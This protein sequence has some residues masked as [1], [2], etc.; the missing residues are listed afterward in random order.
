MIVTTAALLLIILWKCKRTTKGTASSTS[1]YSTTVTCDNHDS[2][3]EPVVYYTSVEPPGE[4]VYTKRYVYKHKYYLL[5]TDC[6]VSS[7]P[8]TW[9]IPNL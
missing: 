9:R 1:D 3:L 8:L 5:V 4:N 6:L 2:S 7:Q